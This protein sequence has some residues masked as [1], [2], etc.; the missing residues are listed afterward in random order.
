M[1]MLTLIGCTTPT[2]ERAPDTAPAAPAQVT[3]PPTVGATASSLPYPERPPEPPR[4]LE[5]E[6]NV[7][8]AGPEAIKGT[9]NAVGKVVA[10]TIIG[11]SEA[12]VKA[13]FGPPS[14]VIPKYP[15]HV[16]KYVS[17][18]CAM[19]IFFYLDIAANTYRVLTLDISPETETENC[20]GSLA[21]A[22]S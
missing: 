3:E 8:T 14:G 17:D 10:K 18:V 16:W 4:R 22:K 15:G 9:E 13:L 5:P 11:E 2:G 21:N 1:G 12:G 6:T 19:E 7:T 20:Y